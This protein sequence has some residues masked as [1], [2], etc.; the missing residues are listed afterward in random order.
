M[1]TYAARDKIFT[2]SILEK[3]EQTRIMTMPDFIQ[4]FHEQIYEP[5]V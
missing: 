4:K 1:P 3:K 5:T 2:D